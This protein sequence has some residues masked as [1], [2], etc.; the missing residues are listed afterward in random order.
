MQTVTVG[1]PS[2]CINQHSRFLG[3][4][5][6]LSVL[7]LYRIFAHSLGILTY[8]IVEGATPTQDLAYHY[9]IFVNMK[10]MVLPYAHRSYLPFTPFIAWLSENSESTNQANV[11]HF[12]ILGTMLCGNKKKMVAKKRKTVLSSLGL[13]KGKGTGTELKGVIAINKLPDMSCDVFR[14][15]TLWH[16]F[17]ENNKLVL[18][19]I[20]TLQG[21]E[22]WWLSS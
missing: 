4:I 10:Q 16:L 19:S 5:F 20:I 6:I 9:Q 7:L 17:Q 12:H 13:G 15:V 18:L 2:S 1:L 3:N 14:K 11:D 21:R 8:I 22:R